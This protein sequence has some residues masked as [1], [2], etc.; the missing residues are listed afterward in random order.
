MKRV[1]CDLLEQFLN[2]ESRLKG[3]SN[4]F[5]PQV[6]SY[7]KNIPIDEKDLYFSAENQIAK[8]CNKLELLEIK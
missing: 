4:I 6:Y 3:V 2:N 8:F 7:F 1:P 5:F